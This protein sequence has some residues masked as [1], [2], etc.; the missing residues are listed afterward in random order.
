M[1]IEDAQTSTEAPCKQKKVSAGKQLNINR[2][3]NMIIMIMQ[4]IKQA[5]FKHNM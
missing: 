1:H 2:V 5:I 3:K 4:S